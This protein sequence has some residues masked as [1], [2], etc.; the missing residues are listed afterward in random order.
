[1]NK[2]KQVDRQMTFAALIF[3]MGVMAWIM[4]RGVGP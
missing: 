3:A 1:M 4:S 2:Q